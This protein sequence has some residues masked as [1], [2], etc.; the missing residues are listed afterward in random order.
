[1]R[2]RNCAT[3]RLPVYLCMARASGSLSSPSHHTAVQCVL[4]LSILSHAYGCPY[5]CFTP[6]LRS[7]LSRLPSAAPQSGSESATAG[8]LLAVVLA[9][10][11]SGPTCCLSLTPLSRPAQTV[12]RRVGYPVTQSASIYSESYNLCVQQPRARESRL[13]VPVRNT[14]VGRHRGCGGE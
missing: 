12:R 9:L 6:S 11:S 13:R 3:A 5:A 8:V 10:R 7:L 14:R 4:A 1:M 2:A